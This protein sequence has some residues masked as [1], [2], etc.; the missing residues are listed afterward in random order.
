MDPIHLLQAEVCR[1]L[2]HPTRIAALHLLAAGPMTVS[3]LSR[4]LGISQPNASQHLAVM[5]AAGLVHAERDGREV[6]YRLTDPDI[7]NACQLMA[8]VMRHRLARMA[9]LSAQIDAGAAA[10]YPNPLPVDA[11]TTSRS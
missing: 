1:T 4:D 11:S 6:S 5:K 10:L 2:S 7:I 9:T 3:A 8:R